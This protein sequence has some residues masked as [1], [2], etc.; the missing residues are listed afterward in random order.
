[1]GRINP[2]TTLYFVDGGGAIVASMGGDFD[3][4]VTSILS[5]FKIESSESVIN[6]YYYTNGSNENICTA[7]GILWFIPE[8]YGLWIGNKAGYSGATS[9]NQKIYI[10]VDT[11][12]ATNIIPSVNNT[13]YIGSSSK[14]WANIYTVDLSST[15]TVSGV[16][17]SATSSMSHHH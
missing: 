11:M 8:I 6:A 16:T 15:G 4:G 7:I 5:N 2:T 10:T 13:Y 17:I 9:A 3:H 12:D 14:R 1:M